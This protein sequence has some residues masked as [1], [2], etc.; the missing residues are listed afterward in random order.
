[1]SDVV[2]VVAARPGPSQVTVIRR[3][4]TLIDASVR[5]PSDSLFMSFSAMKPMVSVL[6]HQLAHPGELDLDAPISWLWPKFAARGKRAVTVRDVLQHRSGLDVRLPELTAVTD[7]EAAARVAAHLP[8]RRQPDAGAHYQVLGY[9]VVLGEVCRRVTGRR[10]GELID[11]RILAPIGLSGQAFLG[12]PEEHDHRGVRLTGSGPV[13]S[14]VARVARSER[15]RRAAIASGGLWT[16]SSVLAR[17]YDALGRGEYLPSTSVSDLVTQSSDGYDGTTG[18][19]TRWA[20]GVQLG[21]VPG[22]FFGNASTTRTFGHNGSN[23]CIGWHDPDRGLSLGL[24]TSHIW[25]P[26]K[27]VRHFREVADAALEMA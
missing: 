9:G 13:F 7:A 22:S 8:A 11:A 5:T 4:E 21:G 27:A 17:F 3:G 2:K 15:V 14:T 20:N 1:M 24:V 26:K 10:L 12:L 6:I 18:L 25:P 23:I 19:A 16:S